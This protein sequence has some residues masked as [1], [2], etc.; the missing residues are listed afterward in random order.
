[1]MN[2]INKDDYQFRSMVPTDVPEVLVVERLSFSSPWSEQSFISELL[3]NEAAHY[4]VLERNGHIAAYAGLW[5]IVGEGHITNIAVHPAL[6]GH[7]LG[8]KLVEGLMEEAQSLKCTRCT[9]EVR[10]SNTEAIK[11]YESFGFHSVGRRPGY[12]QDTGE[13]ALIMWTDH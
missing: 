2:A 8:R 9:L 5:A 10:P 11:L 3:Y 1:M 6:R 4:F 12:Y 7:G 13:D